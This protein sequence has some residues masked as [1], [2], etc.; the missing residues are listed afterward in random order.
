MAKAELVG[1]ILGVLRHENAGAGFHIREQWLADALG[2]S[3]SPVR[4]ALG[5]LERLGIVRS[6]HRQGYFL[7][8]EPG[9]PAFDGAEL[10]G[11]DTERI[12]R[13]IAQE[14]F[15][16][17]IGDQVSVAELCRRYGASRAVISRVLARMQEDG[18]VEKTAGRW[19]FRPA[20]IDDE[21]YRES[22]RYRLLIEPAALLEPGFHMPRT[23]LARL[24][25]RHEEMIGGGARSQPM[26]ALFDADAE[27]HEA[28]ADACG[29]RFLMLAI[30]QQTQLRRLS[31]YE[32]YNERGRLETSFREHLAIL[33]A[34][35]C[36]DL[37]AASRLMAEHIRHSEDSRP[38]LAKVRVLAHRRLTRI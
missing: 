29:N 38:D 3:R 22:Y 32:K 8:A 5:E 12:Y 16:R 35:E 2:V 9:S 7:A 37:A 18:L 13:Q 15:A 4:A 6:E 14:R 33:N 11:S 28:I 1:K 25:Q 26:P 19:T 23:V 31:E 24:K 34:I 21:A 27:F 17:L 30:R 20:L 36:R 10:P